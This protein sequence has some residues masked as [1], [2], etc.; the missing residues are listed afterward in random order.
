MRAAFR[1]H[2]VDGG[3]RVARAIVSRERGVEA[4]ERVEVRCRILWSGD[5]MFGGDIGAVAVVAVD[6]HR[7]VA[8]DVHRGV[9]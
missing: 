8:I 2:G 1:E 9:Q 6:V 7:G 3:E 5:G 4:R